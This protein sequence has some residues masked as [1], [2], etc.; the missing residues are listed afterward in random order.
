[1]EYT[2][3]YWCHRSSKLSTCKAQ[4]QNTLVQIF[5]QPSTIKVPIQLMT[6][7]YM[8]LEYMEY[9][10][11]QYNLKCHGHRVLP[12]ALYAIMI[13][14]HDVIVIHDGRHLFD[15]FACHQRRHELKTTSNYQCNS[16]QLMQCS[17]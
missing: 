4:E 8:A 11:I 3:G 7:I 14:D 10:G 13:R 6:T 16:G 9:L 17:C 2:I 15:I 5:T 1:M 12:G